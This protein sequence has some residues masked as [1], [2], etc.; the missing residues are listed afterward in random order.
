MTSHRGGIGRHDVHNAVVAEDASVASQSHLQLCELAFQTPMDT[1]SCN[2]R[3]D[4][5]DSNEAKCFRKV[6]QLQSS[7]PLRPDH[8][9]HVFAEPL[10]TSC[11]D[12]TL[13]LAEKFGPQYESADEQVQ[14]AARANA[15]QAPQD[16]SARRRN[17]LIEDPN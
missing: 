15:T 3:K 8:R 16:E 7:R 12:S 5:H 1:Q 10:H 13:T 4:L 11:R 2:R 14:V 6:L 17:L 9:S